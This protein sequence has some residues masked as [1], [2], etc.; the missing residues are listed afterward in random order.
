MNDEAARQ[1]R[2]DTAHLSPQ[3]IGRSGESARSL[4]EYRAERARRLEL[5]NEYLRGERERLEALVAYA[6]RVAVAGTGVSPLA[7]LDQLAVLQGTNLGRAA[8]IEG[9]E[10]EQAEVMLERVVKVLRETA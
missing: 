1:G 4:D 8:F 10:R 5:E 3:F 6:L 7:L 9:R 2:P